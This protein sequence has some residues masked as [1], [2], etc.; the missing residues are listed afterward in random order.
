LETSYA[1]T[2]DTVS[3]NLSK[4]PGDR[5]FVNFTASF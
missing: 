3:A 4:R 1:H 5:V 2:L